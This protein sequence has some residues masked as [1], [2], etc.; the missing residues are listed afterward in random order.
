MIGVTDGGNGE[1]IFIGDH[2]TLVEM[3]FHDI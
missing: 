3:T 2:G 1:L